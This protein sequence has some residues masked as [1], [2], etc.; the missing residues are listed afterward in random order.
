MDNA[1]IGAL[2]NHAIMKI[3]LRFD[4]H[5]LE[6]IH[7]LGLR[8]ANPET[9]RLV[10]NHP[11]FQRT[12]LLRGKTNHELEPRHFEILVQEFC[13]YITVD[14]AATQ[15]KVTAILDAKSRNIADSIFVEVEKEQQG[16]DQD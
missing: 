11:V 2:E 14:S 8:Q 3:K 7:D 6:L 5:E 1:R 10:Q 16:V 9:L 15:D 13:A 12:V 4:P